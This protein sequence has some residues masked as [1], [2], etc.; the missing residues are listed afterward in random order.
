MLLVLQDDG[1]MATAAPGYTSVRPNT[2][3]TIAGILSGD[4]RHDHLIDPARF[5]HLIMA[6]Q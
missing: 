3:A 6:K 2:C 5:I 4:D 1:G